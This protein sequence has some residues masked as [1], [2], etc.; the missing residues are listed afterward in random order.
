[1]RGGD[2]LYL[3]TSDGRRYTY[4]MQAEY[5]TGKK[6]AEILWTTNALGG[7]TVSLVSCT[8]LNRL[9]TNT[10]YRLISTFRFV[11]LGRSRLN[12]RH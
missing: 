9:P 5:L 10:S 12:S 11:S 1:M 7:E 2:L 6:P 3:Q 4:Q 8:K